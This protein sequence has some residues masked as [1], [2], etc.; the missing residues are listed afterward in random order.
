MINLLL[1]VFLAG[2]SFQKE[3]IQLGLEVTGSEINACKGRDILSCVLADVDLSSF[4]DDVLV[5]PGGVQVTNKNDI[6]EPI[7]SSG[8]L[9]IAKSVAYSGQ[10]C[11]AV[12]SFRGGKVIGNIEYEDGTD[13]VL[14]PCFNFPGCH[15]WKEEDTAH[16]EE[17]EGE[18]VPLEM[19]SANLESDRAVNKLRQQGIDDDTTIVWYSIK[20]YYTK[21]FAAATDDIQLYMDQVIAET[22]QGYINSKIP[23][24]VKIFCIEATTLNDESDSAKLF[25]KFVSYKGTTEA[26]RGS[27]DAAALLLIDTSSCGRGYLDSW[28][29]G[30][31]ITIQAKGCALGYY[32]MGH[33]L[34]HN[35]GS[36]HDREHS[37]A[38]RYYSYG[39]GSYIEPRYRTIMGYYKEGYGARVNYYSSPNVFYRGSPTG[40]DTEDTARV[41]KENRFGFAAVGDESETCS[42]PTSTAPVTSTATVT[43][44]APFTATPPA[45]STPQVTSLGTC[46]SLNQL[47]IGGDVIS[48]SKVKGVNACQYSCFDNISCTHWTF[49]QNKRKRCVLMSGEITKVK[50]RKKVVSGT[51]DQC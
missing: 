5:L 47:Y 2:P 40:S 27:A 10:G 50:K 15:V 38:N 30:N 16:M 20:Y 26:L 12:F 23:I 36:T 48:K 34:A 25:S 45:S 1:L 43:S 21:E 13:F 29:N 44:T 3:L 51:I 18:E 31:T 32:T 24:R 17:E 33:E 7:S 28:D 37:S 39:H 4:D 42:T 49:Y 6:Q 9:D 46:K 19:R 8:I 22:N 14:E 11:E 35:F 41:I